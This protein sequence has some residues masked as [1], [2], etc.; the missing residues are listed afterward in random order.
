M[1]AAIV[2]WDEATARGALAMPVSD[3]PYRVGSVTVAT[4]R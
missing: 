4:W 2:M 3:E 1:V